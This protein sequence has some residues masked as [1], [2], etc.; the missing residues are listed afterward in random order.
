[1]NKKLQLFSL[2]TMIAT[3]TQNF[4]LDLYGA[5]LLSPRSQS[6]NAAR[7]MVGWHQFI[8]L[9]D[10]HGGYKAGALTFE[11]TRT[12]RSR[13]LAEFFFSTD[14][15]FLSGSDVTNRGTEDLLADYFG[16]SQDFFGEAHLKPTM[17]NFIAD[18]EYYYGYYNW[19]IRAHAP[20]VVTR[21]HI[22]I[23]EVNDG[24]VDPFFPGYMGNKEVP[25]AYK[26]FR[27]AMTGTRGFG[28]VERL[29]YG[30][31]SCGPLRTVKLS[32]IQ[33][34]VGNN[35][36]NDDDRHFGLNL[37]VS[38]P[39]GTRPD[40]EFLF[41]PIVGN[42]HHWELG[43]GLTSHILVWEKDDD[44][45]INILVDANFMHLLRTR[46][47]RSFDTLPKGRNCNRAFGDRYS[48]AKEF[49]CCGNYT[50]RTL[51][52]IN[53]LTLCCD[54]YNVIQMDAALLVAYQ[55]KWFGFDIGY[56]AWLR[57]KDKIKCDS[58]RFPNHKYAFKG[59]QNVAA[60]D[61]QTTQSR[62]TL[63]GNTFNEQTEVADDPSPVFIKKKNINLMS[64]ESPLSE[65]HKFF[66]LMYFDSQCA[67]ADRLIPYFG[68]GGE[69]EFEGTRPKDVQPN[70]MSMAQW[71]IWFQT[72]FGWQ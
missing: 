18:A 51:P 37:R 36:I 24:A 39:T 65:T 17:W 35:F 12:Y 40:S 63:H 11:F 55:Y 22:E 9:Y 59:I 5:S 49:D 6:T 26:S 32:D 8:N 38:I 67:Q 7:D 34:A 52:A 25:V 46:Q 58:I 53:A 3:A 68:F 72:G 70:Y 43:I 21:T 27:S 61:E 62:A 56:N 64:A 19:Y 57:T 45:A 66:W 15:L 29:R 60:P 41:E 2:L 13:A 10:V 42:G 33:V 48:L 23:E 31:I 20:L 16:L 30:K 28:E 54:V 14:N 50:G 1:M 4:A 71:G 44:Q 47:R 69:V